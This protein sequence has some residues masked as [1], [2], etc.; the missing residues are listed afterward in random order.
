MATQGKQL[1]AEVEELVVSL[2]KHH[3]EELKTGKYVST[4][5]PAG[6]TA[7]GLGIGVATVK[8]IMA[9][10]TQSGKRV[11]ARSKQKPGRPPQSFY[12]NLQPLVRQFIRSQNLEGSHLSINQLREFI[13]R[14]HDVNIP[15]TSLWRALNRWGFRRNGVLY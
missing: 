12:I 7:S 9:R 10:Y 1:S 13:S 14:K 11:V 15:K 4:K 2:K 5:D 8:R 3:D 6:R